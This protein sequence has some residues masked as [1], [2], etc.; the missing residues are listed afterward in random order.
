[1]SVVATTTQIGDWVREVG[2]KNVTVHQILQPNTDPHD[3]EPRPGDVEATSGARVVFENGDNLD[4]WM[5][6]V[7]SAAGVKPTV[8]VLG[9]T[10]PVKIAGDRSGAEASRF[11]PHWWHDP[12]NAVAAVSAI[13]D[14]LVHADPLHAA[15]YRRAAAA[16]TAR[17]HTLDRRIAA[18]VATVPAAKR[19][20]V[21][22]H[23]AFNYFAARYGINVV[24]AVIPSQ[25]TQAEPSAGAIAKLIALVRREHVRAVFPESSLSPKLARAVARETGARSDFTLYGDTL[26]PRG[27]T[28]ATYIR[29]ERANADSMVRG[30]TG[31]KRG[32]T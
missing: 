22:D 32:C 19:T 16:Y 18:C 31:G 8:V 12:R 27:S 13:R 21:T 28:G 23:D 4:T 5:K 26:G 30:F 24:G 15:A 29:M 17:L 7:I 11:D 25:T 14:A 3:Y 10:V 2:G 6:K 9:D 1:M 20:L